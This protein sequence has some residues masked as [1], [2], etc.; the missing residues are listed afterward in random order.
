[1]T[2]LQSSFIFIAPADNA[3][4]VFGSMTLINLLRLNESV[5]FRSI[6]MR[7]N[8]EPLDQ[9]FAVIRAALLQSGFVQWLYGEDN[10]I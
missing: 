2:I 7:R 4:E 5:W 6:S 8:P 10:L 3:D 1:M 9:A